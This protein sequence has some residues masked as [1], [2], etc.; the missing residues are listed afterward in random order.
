LVPLSADGTP[1]NGHGTAV[2]GLIA[3][4]DRLT[5]GVAQ[6]LEGVLSVR[7]G[8]DNGYSNSR[9]IAEG[10]VAAVDAGVKVVNISFASSGDSPLV[11]AAIEYAQKAGVVI[12]AAAGNNGLERVSY[13]AANDGVI[14]VGAVDANGTAMAFSNSGQALAAMSPGFAVNAAWTEGEAVLFSGTSAS[15]PILSGAIVA[16]MNPGNGIQRTAQQA[17]DLVMSKLND[18]GAPGWDPV[19]GHGLLDM[20]R[21]MNA[22]VP[23]IYDAAL[24]SNYLAPPVQGRPYPEL[25]VVIQNRGTELLVNTSVLVNTPFG[26]RPVNITNL[27]P[28]QI[29]TFGVPLPGVDWNNPGTLTFDSTVT[30]ADRYADANPANNRRAD[31]YAP[32]E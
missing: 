10:I 4:R 21:V 8:D 22:G 17:A 18:A 2:A 28:D 25:Q 16:A 23:G 24:A 15:A 32:A 12:V 7:I 13:P 27:A 3:G 1:M 30:V 6:G 20:S 26:T 31:T 19:Y 14:A 5:P 11:R 9:W 29:Y